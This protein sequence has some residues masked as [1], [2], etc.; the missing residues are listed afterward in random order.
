MP[1][2]RRVC[3]P[4]PVATTPRSPQERAIALTF[5]RT[6]RLAAVLTV[7]SLAL[8][9]C[10]GSGA[11]TE[12]AA[13][14]GASAGPTLSGIL[15]G[16]GAS[17]Q[18]SA[19]EAWAAGFQTANGGA[20]VNYDP[21]GSGGGRKQFTSGGV[22]FAGT[23]RAMKPEELTAAAKRCAPGARVVDLP[24]YISP[25]AVAFNLDGITTLNLKPATIAKIFNQKITNWNSPEIKADNPDASLPDLKITPVNRSDNSGTTENFT[26]YLSVAA[27]ADWPYEAA[28]DWPVAGGEAANGTSGV[29]GAIKAG[30]GNIGYADASQV[31]GLGKTA[32]GIGSSFV[33][34]SA[35]KAAAV[36]AESPRDTTRMAGDIVIKVARDTMKAEEYPIV[37]VSYLLACTNYTDAAK[38]G[39]AKAFL[40]YVASAKGQEAAAKN[41]GSA[42]ISDKL[43]TD[44]QASIDA[45]GGA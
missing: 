20:T 28:G 27:K 35:D 40:T 34:Y 33:E 37:L 36:V 39:L 19:M 38:N 30:K 13:S 18:T 15:A 45:I 3:R 14:G 10:G 23:D 11:S 2:V 5:H 22:D 1:S 26:D 7:G 32:V 42:P 43:R 21:V 8:A 12:P 9:A 29:V 6:T 41:A 16:A 4:T 44:V 31:T 17:S 25:I 24:V